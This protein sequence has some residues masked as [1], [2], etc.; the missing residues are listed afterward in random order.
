MVHTLLAGGL[1]TVPLKVVRAARAAVG[2]VM[3]G[4]AWSPPDWLSPPLRW[5][6]LQ[7]GLYVLGLVVIVASIVDQLRPFARLV[8]ARRIW[9]DAVAVAGLAAVCLALQLRWLSAANPELLLTGNDYNTYLFNA[10]AASTGD[11]SLF[12]PDKHL[13][14][15]RLVAWL[16]R[17]GD[18]RPV[19][20]YVSVVS[21][22]MLGPVTYL[23]ARTATSSGGAL[24]A[25]LYLVSLPL[26][27]SY[28]T[29]TTAYALFYTVVVGAAGAIVWALTRPSPGSGLLA[30]LVAGL[31]A[32]TQEK[33]LVV[34]L[35]VLGLGGVLALPA[36]VAARPRWR[37]PV[38]AACLFGAWGA[39]TWVS[40]PPEPYTPLVS[41]VTNQREEIHVDLPYTWPALKQPDPNDPARI[42]G[43]LPRSLWNGEL[44]SWIAAAT[45]PSDSNALRLSFQDGVAR[46]TVRPNTSLPP[47]E[48][49]IEAN[50]R[51]LRTVVGPVPAVGIGLVT[52]GALGLMV[53]RRDD[54][55]GP[56]PLAFV[57][58]FLSGAAPLTLKFGAHYFPHLLPIY[59][60]VVVAGGDALLQRALPGWS[61]WVG[62][63]VA[64][65]VLAA[66]GL[67]MWTG[68]ADAWRSPKVV[69]PPPA[70][71]AKDDPGAYASNLLHVARWL[72]TQEHPGRII[73]CVPGSM[74]LVA[75]R[76]PRFAHERGDAHCARDLSAAKA[77]DWLV[78]SGHLEYRSPRI[79]APLAVIAQGWRVV[80]G[81]GPHGETNRPDPPSVVLVLER[82]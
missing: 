9:V 3:V 12:N 72:A 81:W 13:F 38:A 27:W 36:L 76:D 63:A 11:W 2:L 55:T 61:L 4:A 23:V 34:L 5:L 66:H 75:H 70:A 49:R 22:A 30:G 58:V 50:M 77:G 52:L 18:L 45:T 42:R 14:H 15:G 31:A 39:V 24:V 57:G 28:A 53:R 60:V 82:G 62:R 65:V 68:S 54:R 43:W 32:A 46:W 67:A 56:V 64:L 78:S 10:L 29:Q 40:T 71:E 7:Q 20:V 6:P 80:Y 74:I 26:P 79:P 25:A 21:V 17:G 33:A 1:I 44:E 35:P 59:A 41:L 73:D 19:L 47:V 51:G 37:A 69:F 48:R 8:P 16:A